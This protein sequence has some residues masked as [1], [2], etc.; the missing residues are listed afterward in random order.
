MK[1]REGNKLFLSIKQDSKA[2]FIALCRTGIRGK[3]KAPIF[4]V[5]GFYWRRKYIWTNSVIVPIKN[6]GQVIE[7]LKSPSG[8]LTI[9]GANRKFRR[10]GPLVPGTKMPRY[11]VADSMLVYFSLQSD[12]LR[13]SIV[14]RYGSRKKGKFTEREQLHVT[15]DKQDISYILKSLKKM[16]Q[17]SCRGKVPLLPRRW[18]IKNKAL[19]FEIIKSKEAM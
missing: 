18:T 14:R 8:I 11:V 7:W 19:F 9:R 3:Y 13:I 4:L 2:M 12:E 17:R 15:V 10:V 16:V 1:F 5:T 6:M